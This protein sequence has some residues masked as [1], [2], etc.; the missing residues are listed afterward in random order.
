MIIADTEMYFGFSKDRE[1]V[2]VKLGEVHPVI[3][4]EDDYVNAG[5]VKAYLALTSDTPLILGLARVS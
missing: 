4:N 5:N 1:G 3:V 2:P